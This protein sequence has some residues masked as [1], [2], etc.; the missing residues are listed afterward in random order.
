L[1]AV[2][3]FKTGTKNAL[4]AKRST[5]Q[6]DDDEQTPTN[7]GKDDAWD[8]DVDYDKEFP[9]DPSANKSPD[10]AL[11]WDATSNAIEDGSGSFLDTGKLGIQL[12][13]G[14]IPEEQI[15]EI[16]AAA[17]EVINEAIAAGIDDIEALRANMKKEMD[18]QRQKMKLESEWQTQK[19]QEQLM[20]KID[21][22]TD[23]FLSQSAA[24]RRSTK[25]A[26]AADRAMKGRGTEMG[27]WGV[28]GDT[29]VAL[30]PMTAK[31]SESTT[32]PYRSGVTSS[33]DEASSVITGPVVNRLV[34]VADTRQ[35]AYAKQLLEPLTDA[36]RTVIADV[37]VDVFAPTATLPLGGN[38]AAAV[39]L[40]LTSLS[41]AS[42]V[43]NALER[44]LRRTMQSDGK[45][46]RPPT[47]LVAVSTVGTERTNKMPY[48]YVSEIYFVRHVSIVSFMI[49]FLYHANMLVLTPFHCFWIS[50]SL[51]LVEC[52]TC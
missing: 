6:D 1:G 33:S 37:Q 8:D 52:K 10:P 30:D 12:D 20:R 18:Q 48:S 17:T 9:P 11:P 50:L 22:L 23:D 4:Q 34:V 42:S 38:N 19:A 51:F 31:M 24:S 15:Q 13:L 46:A 3:S 39:L 16:K 44:L 28:L 7:N 41:D 45:V 14:P 43:K 21:K 5:N 25:L 29:A 32:S 2:D 40:F 26:A 35:D 36:L 27:S 47:Q 49:M